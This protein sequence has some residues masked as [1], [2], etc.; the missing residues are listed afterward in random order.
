ML[1]RICGLL[2]PLAL[3][4]SAAG[5]IAAEPAGP[6]G[7]APKA[8]PPAPE[9]KPDKAAEKPAEPAQAEPEP[10]KAEPKP[11]EP[12]KTKPEKPAEP[13][14]PDKPGEVEPQLPT[15]GMLIARAKLLEE[16]GK[17]DEAQSVLLEALRHEPRNA[18]AIKLLG[19]IRTEIRNIEGLQ[20]KAKAEAATREKARLVAEKASQEAELAKAREKERTVLAFQRAL[21]LYRK[22]ELVRAKQLLNDI[23]EDN[24]YRLQVNHLKRLIDERIAL[25]DKKDPGAAGTAKQKQKEAYLLYVSARS[26][27]W[28]KKYDDAIAKCK[29][30]LKTDEYHPKARQLYN[31]ARMAEAFAL[32]G[33]KAVEQELSVLSM[34]ALAEVAATIPVPPPQERRPEPL[35]FENPR[36]YD[37]TSLEEKLKQRISVNLEA[38]PLQYLL[39]IISRGAGLSIITDPAAIEGL[40]L[41]VHVENITLGELLEYIT[42]TLGLQFTM[43]KDAMWI[44]T[45]EAPVLTYKIIPLNGLT[46][47]T[48]DDPPDEDSDMDKLFAKIPDLIEWPDGSDYYID[49]KSTTLVVRSTSEVLK[50]VEALVRIVEAESPQVL[51]E[52]KFIEVDTSLFEDLGVDITTTDDWTI[53][54]KGGMDK[55]HIDAGIGGTFPLELA[56]GASFPS[57]DSAGLTA[58]LTGIMTEPKFQATLKVLKSKANATT[59]SEPKLLALSNSTAEIEVTRDLWYV[60]DFDV[61]R[62]NLS[63]S[64]IGSPYY[65]T[66]LNQSSLQQLLGLTGTGTTTT[67]GGI[68]SLSEPIVIPIYTQAEPTGFILKITPSVGSDRRSVTLLI[69]PEIR[70]EIERLSSEIV[71][72]GTQQTATV[73]RPVISTRTLITK[74]VIH[75]GYWVMIGGLLRQQKED[76][77]SK[78]P[79]LG[80]IPLIKYLFRRTTQRVTKRNLRIFVRAKVVNPKGGT[81]YDVEDVRAARTDAADM[82]LDSDVEI[83]MQKNATKT[84]P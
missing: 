13:D 52:A 61:D 50:D 80:D 6:A 76:R 20:D 66:G 57:A 47:V 21:A 8:P 40:S 5:L 26:D 58:T 77:L 12:A 11:G 82:K 30:I 15:V 49:R 18:E 19:A 32:I 69:E 54:K 51:I 33:E 62:S 9:E 24:P 29:E 42:K 73:E 16:E 75:D 35:T 60:E 74:M 28:H 72:T 36:E 83:L 14:Q 10:P 38:T 37:H 65:N 31:D 84:L 2:L 43:G 64:S 78:V 23:P 17:L 63:G 68:N 53:L 55:M 56:G 34:D 27:Y 71:I 4:L 81:Y 7:D 3:L 67:T 45:P 59:L 22:G 48:S 46:D 25:L 39:D 41:T 79:L 1:K 44:T 70:E